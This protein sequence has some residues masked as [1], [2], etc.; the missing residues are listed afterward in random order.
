MKKRLSDDEIRALLRSA[1]PLLDD[2][3]PSETDAARLRRAVLAEA[4]PATRGWRLAPA[5]A[6]AVLLL[7]AL[8]AGFTLFESRNHA[9]APPAVAAH[10]QRS[11]AEPDGEETGRRQQVQF[12]TAN[13]TR[14]IWVLSSDLSL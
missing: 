4:R 7:V 8:N 10:R 13:G 2:D 5:L 12:V 3:G 11:A 1:D 14:V 9:A 6:A